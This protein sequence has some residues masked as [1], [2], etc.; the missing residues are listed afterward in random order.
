MARI[1]CVGE[2]M[3]E[4]AGRKGEWDLRY[5]GDML[6]TAIHLSRGGHDVALLTALGKDRLSRRLKEAWADEGLDT[7]L[8]LEHPTRHAGLYAID[9][10]QAGARSFNYWRENSAARE[11]F[12]LADTALWRRAIAGVDLL[13]FSLISLAILPLNGR[14]A[15]LMLADMAREGGGRVAFSGKYRPALWPSA[16]EA[17]N[18]CDRAIGVASFGLA[19]REDEIQLGEPGDAEQIAARWARLGCGEVVVKLGREGTRLPDGHIQAPGAVFTP[20]D[21][22]GASDAFDAGY[23]GARLNGLDPQAAALAGERLA[24]QTARLTGSIPS[25]AAYAGLEPGA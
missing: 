7:S 4:L 23:L 24:A 6:N 2:G 3:L 16:E 5:G 9:F 14:A 21:A 22:S 12:A 1:V 10:D 19:T 17:R 25:R 13:V 18:W 11:M 20:L 15:L 8:I